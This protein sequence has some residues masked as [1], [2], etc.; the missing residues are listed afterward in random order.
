[1]LPRFCDSHHPLQTSLV[2]KDSRQTIEKF[3]HTLTMASEEDN[4]DIDIYGDGET[5]ANGEDYKQDDNDINLD[6]SYEEDQNS[7]SKPEEVST[8]TT[9]VKGETQYNE[10]TAATFQSAPSQQSTPQ[11]GIK[12]KESS[13]ERP[14]DPGATLAI[15]ISDLHWWTTEDDVRGWANQAACEEELKDVTFS[16]H[17]VNG[18]SKGYADLNPSPKASPATKLRDRQAFVEFVSPQAASAMKHQVDSLGGGQAGARKHAVSYSNPHQNPFKT[19][20][21]DGPARGKDDRPQRTP[22]SGSYHSPGPPQNNYN[23]T[24][25]GYRGGRSGGFNRGGMNNNI[26]GGFNNNRNFSNPIGGFNPAMGGGFQNNMGAMNSFGGFNHRGGGMM[27]SRGGMGGMRGGRGAN[28]A[29]GMP[30]M[31]GM[32]GMGMNMGMGG[33]GMNPMMTGMGVQGPGGFQG[34]NAQF[35]PAFFSQGQSGAGG[36]PSWNP[37]GAKRTRQE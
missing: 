20:P 27:G 6:G 19:Y 37:H 24:G 15:M 34:G 14:V 21:K 8:A 7:R 3:S 29:G 11:Q 36:D 32:G 22:S 13:D 23:N 30:M 25:A 28:M 4:F 17:K 5:E 18:K 2:Y 9:A 35:N 26:S 12:R 10:S 31:G 33:G 16:E 1:M